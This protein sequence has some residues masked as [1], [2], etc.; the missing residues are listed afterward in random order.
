M[1]KGALFA[2]WGSLITG[3]EKDKSK[4]FE[5]PRQGRSDNSPALQCWV[6]MWKIIVSPV[7]TTE[8]FSR[9][10][11]TQFFIMLSPA[12]KCWAIVSRP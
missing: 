4:P 1:A 2:G 7:G 9:P 10:Y 8:E 3:S 6:T 12:L 11:G 5:K